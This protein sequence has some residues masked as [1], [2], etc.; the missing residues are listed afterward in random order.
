MC[1]IIIKTI[2]EFYKYL[3]ANVFK[4]TDVLNLKIDINKLN[5]IEKSQVQLITD[6][7][8]YT[9]RAGE[10]LPL[11]TDANG[12]SYPD[13]KILTDNDISYLT[14]YLNES[15]NYYIRAKINH[16]L[17]IKVKCKN[18]INFACAAID[19]YFFLYN[20]YSEL[21]DEN[22]FELSYIFNN[23]VD[24][25]FKAN[26]KI[27]EIKK[28]SIK[29]VKTSTKYVLIRDA[30]EFL[31]G[32]VKKKKFD[33]SV[34]IGFINICKINIKNSADNINWIECFINL[35][36]KL[37]GIQNGNLCQWDL[38][39]AK[40]YE[41]EMKKALQLDNHGLVAASWCER[42]IKY[43]KKAKYKT[44][45]DKLFKKYGELCNTVQYA[46]IDCP[47]YDLKEDIKNLRYCIDKSNNMDILKDL[48]YGFIPK[49]ENNSKIAKQN[50]ANF[51]F[52]TFCSSVYTD[53]YGQVIGYA[54]TD[55]EKY[56]QE[57][58]NSYKISFKFNSILLLNYIQYA[59]L[60]NKLN[61]SLLIEHL[62]TTWLGSPIRKSLPENQV[63]TYQWLEH[64]EQPIMSYFDKQQKFLYDNNFRLTFINEVDSLTL[65][66]EGILRDLVEL[67]HIKGFSV[68]KFV[69]D[70]EGRQ[71]S[72]WKS[73]NELLWDSNISKILNEDDIW[74]MRYFLT[75]YLDVRNNIAHCLVL[76]P[77][78]EQYY[79]GF[80]WLLIIILRLSKY[81]KIKSSL[82]Y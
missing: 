64:L 52:T 63:L 18:K 76:N 19:A 11:F 17:F 60:T 48:I 21:E 10:L 27:D 47:P 50:L 74:F 40:A 75:D 56:K 24:L 9:I 71:I 62:K 3:D 2:N 69:N 80:Q 39:Q 70:K 66:I 13:I 25:V 5:D 37:S 54:S 30:A 58:W 35:G 49:Y 32:K 44:K 28:L 15:K 57:L 79:Y 6:C 59:L 34:L 72:N 33:K 29:T 23:L 45:V 51:S 4:H 7:L 42:A 1:N 43:Y 12:H 68:R 77:Y 82:E 38:L 16:F 26:Y 81:V 67:A 14:N 22:W 36:R 20:Q 55:E 78:Q 53:I 61:A 73:I 31:I 8:K 65:K 46:T 41:N